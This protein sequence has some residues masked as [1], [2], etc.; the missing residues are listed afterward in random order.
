MIYLLF[1]FTGFFIATQVL[2]TFGFLFTMSSFVALL[3]I[4]LCSITNREALAMRLMTMAMLAAGMIKRFFSFHV[5]PIES[6]KCFLLFQGSFVPLQSS[7]LPLEV[8]IKIGCLILSIIY[9]HGHLHWQSLALFVT[10]SHRFC[11][12]LNQKF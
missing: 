3:A 7:Y 6:N 1:T 4:E 9:F 11:F 5:K 8:M 2:Y 10:G 12:M